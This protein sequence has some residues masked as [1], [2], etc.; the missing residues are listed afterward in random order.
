[1][2]VIEATSRESLRQLIQQTPIID[3]HAHPL[4]KK[5]ALN[6]H[7]FLAIATEAHG[8]A[9]DSSK[10]SLAHFRAV[11][12]LAFKL[13][14]QPS[15]EAVENTVLGRRETDYNEWTRDC[16]EGIE[17]VLVDDGLDNADA[18][19]DYKHF[20]QFTRSAAKR[21]VRIEQTAAQLI[22]KACQ[23]KPTAHDALISFFQEFTEFVGKCIRDVEVV[24]FKSVI[25]Y[26][27]GL[28]IRAE[29]P[30]DETREAFETIYN[31]LQA[32]HSKQFTRLEHRALNESIVLIT[33]RCIRD[34][35][36][37]FKKP[38]QFHTG[39]GDNDITLTRSSPAHL[40]RLAREYPT[41][42]IVLLHSGYPF[43]RDAGYLAAMYSNVYTDI[44]EVFPFLS[45][46]GQETVVRE[47]LHLCPWSKIIWSTDG[48][49]F[50]ETYWLAVEQMREAI[51]VV[52]SEYVDKGD[53]SWQQTGQL[54]QDML[55]NNSNKLYNL[56]LSLRSSQNTVTAASKQA[57][58]LQL[59]Q[60]FFRQHKDVAYLRV[61]WVDLT[62]TLKT[63]V[64]PKRH[65]LQQAQDE[66]VNFSIIAGVLGLLPN[67]T[68]APGNTA[69]G[70][71]K[72]YP[73]LHNIFNGPRAGHAMVMT[74]FTQLNGTLA[75]DCPRT[76]L[77]RALQFGRQHELDFLVGFE[78]EFIV[79]RVNDDDL[80]PL[81]KEAHHWS[82][83]TSVNHDA[84]QTSIEEALKILD[85]A[86]VNVEMMHPESAPGQYEIILSKAP[87]LEAVDKLIFARSV[88][89]ACASNHGY[90]VSLHPRPFAHAGATAA[91]LHLSVSRN[92]QSGED[93]Y[94]PFYAGIL[95]H[96]RA[97]CA[98]T[99]SHPESYQRV[100]DGMWTG[101]T[102]V[103][104]GTQNKETPLRKIEGSHWELKCLDGLAN[105]YLAMASVLHAGIAGVVQ[106]EQLH[107]Q[108]C[109]AEPA[110]L[111]VEQRSELGITT[112]L[113]V[114]LNESLAALKDDAALVAVLGDEL[115]AR[116]TSVKIAEMNMLGQIDEAARRL[117]IL[118]HY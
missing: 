104:W 76:A 101:G 67:D 25:C 91:H 16:L 63:R 43:V 1:M 108:D 99:F 17:C 4:L 106:L 60:K 75:P 64:V 54:V 40:Q 95:K 109:L 47:T 31:Q 96:L 29:I 73:D 32:S 102:W 48:H 72:M 87:V 39:L 15:W 34:T 51:F 98:F 86:G 50:P 83:D 20:D 74:D 3:H 107:I 53:L 23:G 105:P 100:R 92:G 70:Q 26:R 89:N 65:L 7:P 5:K 36:H 45:R 52:L 14:C 33:A 57:T 68:L 71:Y 90:K 93:L 62:G 46:D 77:Q 6:Q 35:P 97:I 66:R 82:R 10:K 38:I 69:T 11:N 111:S 22:N 94:E 58:D 113:P 19:E 28:N 13:K 18:V 27:T 44:G 41:V 79:F 12:Q 49:W 8:D 9:L 112:K 110:K 88:L 80:E 30:P 59:L 118:Q 37:I 24:G 117:W 2:A 115:V 42:P 55:F 114:D 116:Y 84:V 81:N 103:A 21:I 85:D 56:N 61:S 78:I